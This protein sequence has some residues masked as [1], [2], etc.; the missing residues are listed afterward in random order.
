MSQFN[1]LPQ[2]AGAAGF[3]HHADDAPA[4]WMQDILWI[5]LADRDDTGGRWSMMEQLMPMGAGPP[6]TSISGPTR[7]STSSTARSAI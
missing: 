3:I 5:M 2:I 6:P 7:P 1:D 4:Y